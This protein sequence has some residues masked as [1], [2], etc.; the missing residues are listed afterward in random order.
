MFAIKHCP[1]VEKMISKVTKSNNML[2]VMCVRKK[3]IEDREGKGEMAKVE[4]LPVVVG[5]LTEK[6]AC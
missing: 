6:L 4:I 3:T 5:R 1:V 2:G